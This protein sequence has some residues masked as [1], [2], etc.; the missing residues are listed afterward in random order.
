MDIYSVEG[1]RETAGGGLKF[2]SLPPGRFVP[3]EA[4]NG[5]RLLEGDSGDVMVV[6]I[7]ATA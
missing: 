2:R 3:L 6:R 1:H 4:S 5:F 7:W